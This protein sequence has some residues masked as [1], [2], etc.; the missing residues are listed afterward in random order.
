MKHLP[1]ATSES[2]EKYCSGDRDRREALVRLRHQS[3]WAALLL[4]SPWLATIFSCWPILCSRPVTIMGLLP[5]LAAAAHIE[6]YL[7]H[8]LLTNHPCFE[9]NL[10]FSTLGAATWIT[11]L[12]AA[13]IVALAGFLPLAVQ[14]NLGL[15]TQERLAWASGIIYLGISMLDLLDGYVARRQGRE[16]KLGQRLDIV[17]DAAGLLLASLLAVALGRLPIIYLLVGLSYYPFV[18]GIWLRQRRALPVVALQSRP[19][20]R[21]IAGCQMGLVAMALLP[22]FK[23]MFT[24]LA[25]SIFMTPL[26]IGFLRDWLVVSCRIKTDA[27][28]Q[29]R[30]DYW[31]RSLAMKPLPL[32]LRLIIFTG[33]LSTLAGN[34]VFQ[35]HL[36][37]QLAHSLFCLLAALGFMGRSAALFLILLLGSS[38][39]PF[40]ITFLS[41]TLFATAAALMLVG[42]GTMSIWMPEETILYRRSKKSSST[43]C[44]AL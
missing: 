18:F 4:Y 35:T 44:E 30:L 37:W 21:I 28:Q 17:T 19:Y 16:T 11:L 29:S 10:L 36:P 38:Q 31:M 2:G 23:P 3:R 20:A 12:R 42:T 6:R 32:A 33:G 7:S 8:H 27:D 9:E 13:A 41:T 39:S 25:A 40:G 24:Y 1:D 5:G 34:S 43:A 22:I 15:L 14:P 26:L